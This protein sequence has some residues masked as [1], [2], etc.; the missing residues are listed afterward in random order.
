MWSRCEEVIQ[1]QPESHGRER[2]GIM[3]GRERGRIRGEGTVKGES[4]WGEEGKEGGKEGR[5]EW[6]GRVDEE[7]RGKREDEKEMS[8]EWKRSRVGREVLSISTCFQPESSPIPGIPST[9]RSSS[10]AYLWK[11]R[12][13]CHG[14]ISLGAR[15]LSSY[16]GRNSRW[17]IMLH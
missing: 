2:K 16:A 5:E 12:L 6:K 1:S 7:R 13:E 14:I 17:R 3:K 10:L 15:S 8:N 4:R 11:Q 9:S